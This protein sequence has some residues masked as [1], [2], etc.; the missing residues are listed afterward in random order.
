MYLALADELMTIQQI[1]SAYDISKNHL[2]KV[3][4]KLVKAG[5]VESVRGQGGGLRL[6]KCPS[7]IRLGRLVREIEPELALVE[8]QRADNT[9]VITP[10]CRLSGLLKKARD[11]FLS[12]LDNSTLEDLLPRK[13]QKD[14]V[15]ILAIGS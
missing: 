13:T 5:Y 6:R 9:C 12:E 15:R 1:S 14:L 2:M 3:V 8:C 7:D 11:T 10:V 4:Q